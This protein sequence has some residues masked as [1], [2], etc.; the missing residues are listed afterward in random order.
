MIGKCP[1][2]DPLQ[3]CYLPSK[4]LGANEYR[5]DTFSPE[6]PQFGEK[7]DVHFIFNTNKNQ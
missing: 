6:G 7:Y 3:F 5:L 4:K 2:S 1:Y